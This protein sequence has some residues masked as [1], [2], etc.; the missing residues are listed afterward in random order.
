V[1]R[2][3]SGKPRLTV[4]GGAFNKA[5]EVVTAV[6]SN[7]KSELIRFRRPKGGSSGLSHY[8]Y[9]AVA[10]PGPWCIEKL[11]TESNGQVLW[12]ANA[13]EILPYSPSRFCG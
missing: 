2:E 13:S 8:R 1:I 5:V 11:K 4:V 7:G 12:Q 10:K 3:D 9:I 6:R